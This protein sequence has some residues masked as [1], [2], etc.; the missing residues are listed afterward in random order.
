MQTRFITLA[1]SLLICCYCI[2]RSALA[3]LATEDELKVRYFFNFPKFTRWPPP[4]KSPM[5][6]CLLG[7]NPFGKLLDETA[8]TQASAVKVIS[9]I[10][11][12]DNCQVMFLMPQ[13][14]KQLEQWVTQLKNKPILIISDY[15]G[16]STKGVMIELVTHSNRITFKINRKAANESGLDL[17]AALLNLADEVR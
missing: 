5:L 16:S 2:N 15:I 7:E 9:D 1:I 17:Y 4:I 14:D 13:N 3:T 12:A 11:D 6:F 8:K 10:D